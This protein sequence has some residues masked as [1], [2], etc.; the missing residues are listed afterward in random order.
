VCSSDLNPFKERFVPEVS[1]VVNLVVEVDDGSE[2]HI[3]DSLQVD[4]I[5][6]IKTIIQENCVFSTAPGKIKDLKYKIEVDQN[7]KPVASL[8]YKIPFS[9]KEDVKKE[10]DRWLELGLVIK[11]NSEWASPVVTVIN[12]DKSLRLTVD[13][14]KLNPHVNVDNYPMPDRDAVMEKLAD[15]KYMTKLDLTKAY[16]QMPLDESSRKYT[17]FVT[18]IWSI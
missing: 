5:G 7:V 3:N 18:E 14:R 11:S 6:L 13:Y 16:F 8:P 17:S 10:L 9:L 15:A 1:E 2:T 4:Q 12:S